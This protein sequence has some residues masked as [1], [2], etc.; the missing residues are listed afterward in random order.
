MARI[1][2][3]TFAEQL[4]SLLTA[5]V[6]LPE[7]LRLASKS[8]DDPALI[9]ASERIASARER[10]EPLTSADK[11]QLTALPPLLRW[12]L[13]SDL[14]GESLPDMLRFIAETYRQSAQR[15]ASVWH[16]AFPT[17][18]GASF[19]GAIVLAYGLSMF[20]PYIQMLRDLAK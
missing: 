20:G 13:T 3:A 9:A 8:T 5:N 19:G 16:I 7:S 2:R 12:A 4:A 15:Q 10:G 17:L 6:S 1:T 11:E 14:D 18:V